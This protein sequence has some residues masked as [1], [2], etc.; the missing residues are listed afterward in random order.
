MPRVSAAVA[1]G[2]LPANALNDACVAN[3]LPSIVGLQQNPAC[4]PLVW[5]T[6]RMQYPALA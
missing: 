5:A 3:G 6:L 4:V 1:G 2:L